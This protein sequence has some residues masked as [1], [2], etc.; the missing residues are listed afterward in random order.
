VPFLTVKQFPHTSAI[1][2]IHSGTIAGKLNGVMPTTTPS[3]WRKP[4]APQPVML[5]G[6]S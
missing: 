6:A 5:M 1:G 2:N 3:G 4:S